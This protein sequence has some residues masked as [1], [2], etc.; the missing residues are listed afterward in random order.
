MIGKLSGVFL[1]STTNATLDC[2]PDETGRGRFR[3]YRGA[4]AS[5][6][7]KKFL[8]EP[9]MGALVGEDGDEGH[10]GPVREARR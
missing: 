4:A 9:E 7:R 2:R 6:E 10:R 8:F 3:R 5:E 1:L